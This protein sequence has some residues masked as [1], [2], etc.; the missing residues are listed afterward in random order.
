MC[1]KRKGVK[2]KD[3]QSNR[4]ISSQS[5]LQEESARQQLWFAGKYRGTPPP[6]SKS[7][8]CTKSVRL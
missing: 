7:P 4:I 2:K 3:G 8:Y 5:L 6:K 1:K